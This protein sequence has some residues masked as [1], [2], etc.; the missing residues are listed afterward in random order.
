[1]A[2]AKDR[3]RK[4]KRLAVSRK[5]FCAANLLA[6][7]RFQQRDDA[8]LRRA[9]ARVAV[10]VDP[11]NVQATEATVRDVE[12]AARAMGLQVQVLNPARCHRR[13][14]SG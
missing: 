8:E 12:P 10:L 6:A 14:V 3:V 7:G 5:K 4:A 1:L 11:A 9:M 2:Q 13:I